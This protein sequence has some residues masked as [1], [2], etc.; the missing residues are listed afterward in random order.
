MRTKEIYH[1]GLMK[2]RRNVHMG[3]EPMDRDDPRFIPGINCIDHTY[4]LAKDPKYDGLMTV[5]SHL[6]RQKVNRFCPRFCAEEQYR[7]FRIIGDFIA[8]Q[9]SASKLI[10]EIHGGGS[11]AMEKI[12]ILGSYNLEEKKSLAMRLA[13]IKKKKSKSR[14]RVSLGY[15]QQTVVKRSLLDSTD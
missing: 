4:Y 8:S 3:G 13:G 5:Q 11:P 12:A 6:T 2:M 14:R 15:A 7:C 9:F 1:D 10:S